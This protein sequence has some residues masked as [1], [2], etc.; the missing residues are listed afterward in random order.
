LGPV[1]LVGVQG[2]AIH[3]T[4]NCPNKIG[5]NN[6][7]DLTVSVQPGGTYSLSMQVTSCG[8]GWARFAYAFID[9]N[10]NSLWEPSEIL[11]SAI[12][13]DRVT[14]VEV[15][16]SFSVPCVGNGALVGT[17][18]LRV[19]VVEGEDL[20]AD[21][22]AQFN[23]GAV[24]EFSIEILNKPASFCSQPGLEPAKKQMFVD[25]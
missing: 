11:G 3:D 8:Q 16:L 2:T 14:P 23:Y 10:A 15:S 5:L 7:T 18:R 6:L 17:T 12:V 25:A 1:T 21:P 19:F 24:K 9:Y 4:S 22:C 20:P 13:N